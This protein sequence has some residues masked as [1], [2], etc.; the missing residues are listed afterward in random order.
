MERLA[1]FICNNCACKNGVTFRKL[2]IHI[3]AKLKI[4]KDKF[5]NRCLV[6]NVPVPVIEESYD[7]K[8]HT[9]PDEI[10]VC[11]DNCED[12]DG[13]VGHLFGHYIA[14]LHNENPQMSDIVANAIMNMSKIKEKP[15]GQEV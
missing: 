6:W 10:L 4:F 14:D 3:M 9:G 5:K 2:C 12:I 15:H 7:F 13:Q 8:N 1:L 11:L